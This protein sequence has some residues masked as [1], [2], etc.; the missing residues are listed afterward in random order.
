MN[1]VSKITVT[2]DVA[3]VTFRRV[4]NDLG[5][6]ASI[7]TQLADAKVNLDMISQTAPQGHRIDISFTLHSSQLIEVLGLAT[8]FQAAHGLKPMVSN[9]NCKIEL[10]GE[11]MRDMYGVASAAIAAV[12]RTDAELTLI[13]TGEVEISLLV[14][15][16]SCDEAVRA[17][18][19]AFGV[20]AG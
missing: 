7:F 19:E 11:E 15:Q 3:L 8:K 9:G 13:S 16:S 2:E 10:C 1:G 6:L 12:A 20:R 5:V 18:E 4:P 14:P 17:L